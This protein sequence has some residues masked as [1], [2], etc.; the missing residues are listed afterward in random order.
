MIIVAIQSAVNDLRPVL[1]KMAA[2]VTPV[3]TQGRG[4]IAQDEPSS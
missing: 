3:A 4:L 2:R 1:T